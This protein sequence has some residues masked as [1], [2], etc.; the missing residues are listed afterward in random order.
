MRIVALDIMRF[1][2]AL[3]VVLYHYISRHETN[4][5][6]IISEFT[7]YGYLGVPLF[8][9]IS[10]YV[11]AL[12]AENRTALQFGISRFVRLYPT[13]WIGVLFT[14]F[15]V[16]FLTD[17]QYT[18]SQILA[19]FTLLNEYLGLEDVDGVYWTLKA[20]LKF[21]TC[22]FL[23]IS[24]GVF[25]K[26][27]LWLSVWLGLTALHAALGQPFFMGWFIS[28]GYSPFFIAGIACFLIQKKGN[29]FFNVFVISSSLV[30]SS[31]NVFSQAGGFLIDPTVAEKSI[32]VVTVWFFYLLFYLLCIGK[33]K[34]SERKILITMGALTY[35]LY[36]IHNIAG[37]AIIDHY[38]DIIPEKIMILITIALMVS[39]SYLI[40]IFVEKQL[41]TPLKT[42]LIFKFQSSLFLKNSSNT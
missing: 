10:G 11:I 6:P 9:I 31:F 2:A 17:K 29:N 20:E 36:L 4:A 13:L 40:H 41:A 1:V 23:L 15:C 37:K 12:S 18:I 42:F 39:F 16:L 35:P 22:M 26:Y 21:Y 25:H 30:I 19:N 27:H 33:I 32:S 14:V 28:P 3:S 8:F 24:F 5:Y 7:K 38:S 34:L